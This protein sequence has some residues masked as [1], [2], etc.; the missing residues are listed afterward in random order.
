MTVDDLRLQ[1]ALVEV[2]GHVLLFADL[3]TDDEVDLDSAVRLQEA[4]AWDLRRL[5]PDERDRVAR[6]FGDLA[7]ARGWDMTAGAANRAATLRHMPEILGLIPSSDRVS[8]DAIGRSSDGPAAIS[9]KLSVVTGTKAKEQARRQADA[10][11][12]NGL[13]GRWEVPTRDDAVRA[14]RLLRE[15]GAL[16]IGVRIVPFPDGQVG[17][18]RVQPLIEA[19][20]E[21]FCFAELTPD[22]LLDPDWASSLEEDMAA[23]LGAL[24]KP[25][26][27]EL[28]SVIVDIVGSMSTS[29]DRADSERLELLRELPE[30]I[31]LLEDG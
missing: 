12:H 23:T 22:D 19:F 29:G 24:P 21:C 8:D 4:I 28:A 30:S 1:Q 18:H 25:L 17:T 16:E 14:A 9:R 10:L 5:T 15:C 27:L 13:V 6:Q 20:F 3:A 26:R 31:G 7:G 2:I 11:R